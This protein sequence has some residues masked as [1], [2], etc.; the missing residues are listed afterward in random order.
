MHLSPKAKR[1]LIRILPFGLIWLIT[2]S[3]FLLTET[4]V[5]GNQNLSPDSAVTMSLP[6]FIFASIAST[7]VGL[8][9][10]LIEL[11]I[12]EKRFRKFGF[13]RKVITKFSIYMVLMLTIMIIAFPLA[14][15]IELS[16]SPFDPEV[17]KKTANFFQSL[18]FLNT[19]LQISFQLML[20]L[21]YAA[22]SENLGHQ[23]LLNFFTGRY[24]H[25]KKEQRIFMFLDMKSSTTIAEQLGHDRYFNLLQDYYEIMSDPI[26]NTLGDVYQYI[27]DEVVI[28]WESVKGLVNNH[29][30][31]CFYEIQQNLNSHAQFFEK[32]Y[33]LVPGFKAGIHLGE[34]TTGEIGALKKEVVYTGDVLNTTARAQ[35][36]CSEYKSDLIITEGLLNEL[37]DTDEWMYQG[38]GE[39]S[40]KGKTQA[41]KL[42]AVTFSDTQAV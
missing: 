26:I 29:C 19:V 37:S 21:L 3:V 2:G 14:S 30:I 22:I 27:G 11:V 33:G 20:C 17:Q 6:V 42:Y 7:F 12:L 34:V 5:T 41:V 39:L 18:T 4:L 31:K 38:L 8:L 9:V 28:T 25:P 23:V 1:N 40:L 32:N 36:L 15:S 16:K 10:G 35:G 24:H 13:T